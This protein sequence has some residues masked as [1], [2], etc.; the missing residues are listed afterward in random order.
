MDELATQARFGAADHDLEQLTFDGRAVSLPSGPKFADTIAYNVLPFAGAIVKDGSF[1]TD[2]EQKLRNESRKILG[3]DNLAGSGTCVRVPGFT[4]HSLSIN[5]E[6]E[7]AITPQDALAARANAPG[8][9][10]DEIPTPLKAAGM[11][12]S[13]VGRIRVD[14]GV[15]HGLAMFVCGDNLRKGAALNAIQIAEAL[16]ARR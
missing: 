11:D 3:I 8:V 13:L 16:L 12:D 7:R 5:A 9:T 6:F 15:E 2:E 10:L 1:E 14:P 4:G